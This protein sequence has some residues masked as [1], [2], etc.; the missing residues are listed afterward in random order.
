MSKTTKLHF[1]FPLSGPRNGVTVISNLISKSLNP[2][3]DINIID[4]SQAKDYN[5]HGKF[6]FK[7]IL[8]TFSIYQKL[9]TIKKNDAVY[10]NFSLHGFSYYRDLLLLFICTLKC[11]N[12]TIHFHSNGVEKSNL[13]IL[14]FIFKKVKIITIHKKH[15]NS[16]KNYKQKYL[17]PNSLP[18]Y[19]NSN[20]SLNKNSNFLIKLLYFSNIS[21]TKG[22]TLLESFCKKVLNNKQKVSLTICG[23]IL[24]K[25]SEDIVERLVHKYSNIT[26]FGPVENDDIKMNLFH[27]HDI[28]LFFSDENYEVYPLVY[29]EALMNGLSIVTT[30]QVISDE[31]ISDNGIVIKNNNYL[32]YL[33]NCENK[34]FLNKQKNNSRTIFEKK[35]NYGFF[36]K[37]LTNILVHEE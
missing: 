17:L 8:F 36:I 22:V 11:S 9:K 2:F 26:F 3:F 1:I 19:Y 12:I 24:D 35:Y 25:T 34:Y 37:Q 16:I 30:K 7:K 6:S 23:G 4:V 33:S 21:V 32:S 27:K 10:M 14:K 18:D 15:F 5:N 31:I 29:I 20:F 13:F 28:L